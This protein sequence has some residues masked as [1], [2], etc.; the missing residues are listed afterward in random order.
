MVDYPTFD[1]EYEIMRLTTSAYDAVIKPIFKEDEILRAHE[2]VRRVRVPDECI[3]YA[4]SLAR[5]TRTGSGVAPAFVRE[6]LAWGGGPRASQYLILGAKAHAVIDGRPEVTAEDI[7]AVA[8]PVLR[9][10]VMLSYHAE[11]EQIVADEVITELL[12][13]TPAA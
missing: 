12:A 8:H 6:W 4:T 3:K 2:L 7:R 1:D 11:A 10:R 13:C 5:R 9:H